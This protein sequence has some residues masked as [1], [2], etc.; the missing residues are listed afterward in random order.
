M[1]E[2]ASPRG[3]LG[4]DEGTGERKE[5]EKKKG[6]QGEE[7]E[8]KRKFQ[9]NFKIIIFEFITRCKI[10]KRSKNLIMCYVNNLSTIRFNKKI[11]VFNI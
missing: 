11:I 3:R 9:M 7:R 5:K 6:G 10:V 1:T 8:E 4:G 2:C